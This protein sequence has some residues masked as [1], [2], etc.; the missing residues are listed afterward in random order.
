MALRT[1]KTSRHFLLDRRKDEATADMVDIGLLYSRI[2]GLDLG[3][4]YFEQTSVAPQVF[5]RVLS[6]TFRRAREL[7][8]P[9]D[10][11]FA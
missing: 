9:D 1:D 2:Y 7:H 8:E 11:A 3:V 5:D 6:G 4:K 10:P